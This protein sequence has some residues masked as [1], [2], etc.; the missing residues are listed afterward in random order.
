MARIRIAT[1][2]DAGAVA[3]IYASYVRDTVIS[4]EEQAPSPDEMAGRIRTLL[5][6]YPFLVFEDDGAVRGYAYASPHGE[7]SAYRWSVDVTV[8]VEAEAH[9]R[10]VGRSLYRPLLDILVRQGFHAAYAGITL[11]NDKSVGFHEA[12]GFRHIG[13]YDEV[14]FKLGAWR[15]VGWWGLRLSHEDRPSEPVP[16]STLQPS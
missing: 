10:G 16:F 12:M 9:R 13:T 15:D 3:A 2:T 6:N 8:Y 14:G 1:E 7:R 11:P 4:F 5:K